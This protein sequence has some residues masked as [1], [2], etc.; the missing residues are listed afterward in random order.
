MKPARAQ[1]QPRK[2]PATAPAPG[3]LPEVRVNFAQESDLGALDRIAEL[4]VP[5]L[6]PP[7]KR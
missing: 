5:F 6:D 1:R 7:A 3:P 4:L 2:I